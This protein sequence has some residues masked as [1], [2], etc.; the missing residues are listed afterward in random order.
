MPTKPK[1]SRPHDGIATTLTTA[2][3]PALLA[4]H[5]TANDREPWQLTPH[6]S[7]IDR[8]FVELVA[9]RRGRL[10]LSVPV[11][12]GKSTYLSYACAHHL[13]HWPDKSI[14]WASYAST[15]AERWSVAVRDILAEHGKRLAGIEV[16]GPAEHWH[17]VGHKGYFRAAGV[18]MGVTGLGA[19]LVVV[20]DPHKSQSEYDSPTIRESTW[21]WFLSTLLTRLEPDG[22]LVLCA[23]RWGEDDITGRLLRLMAEESYGEPWEHLNLPALAA[24]ENDPLGRQPGEAL[25]PERYSAEKLRSIEQEIGA[26]GFSALYLGNPVGRTGNMFQHVDRLALQIVPCAPLACHR[27]RAWDFSAGSARSDGDYTCG[28]LLCRDGSRFIIEDVKRFKLPPAERDRIVIETAAADRLRYGKEHEGTVFLPTDPGSAG[29]SFVQSLTAA[30]AGY[31]VRT[32][33][34]SGSKSLRAEGIAAQ[35]GAGNVWLA[36]TSSWPVQTCLEELRAFPFG[37]HDDFIDSLSDAFS[38]LIERPRTGTVYA[39]PLRPRGNGKQPPS[40]RLIVA[41]ADSLP[42]LQIDQR[43]L[44]VYIAD[45]GQETA[46]APA[47]Q[48]IDR[49]VLAFADID[50]A[51]AAVQEHWSEPVLPYGRPAAELLLDKATGKRLWSFLTRS[52]GE[53]PQGVLF[54]DQGDRRALSVALAVADMSGLDKAKALWQPTQLEW[55]ATRDMRAPNQHVYR[56]VR[57][58]KLSVIGELPCH[59]P[60]AFRSIGR[61]LSW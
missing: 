5:C 53:A 3:T 61:R 2:G 7:L 23:S 37:R 26:H 51:D 16:A 10:V 56:I 1:T 12:H 52:R 48:Y 38:Q 47:G 60:P 46:M 33:R 24:A 13:L 44:L 30:L 32:N 34:I 59:A 36:N 19:S 14:I 41:A 57:E 4:M 20:D 40:F 31:R 22:I 9:R 42:D 15:L 29:V 39:Y 21:R 49:L 25:W 18:G 50:P 11:R 8:K 55:Q 58:S 35:V 54:V 45:P 27:V 6:L 43:V 17:V 28:T